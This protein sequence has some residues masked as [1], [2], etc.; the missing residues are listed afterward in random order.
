M[1]GHAIECRISTE[2]PWNN[3]LPSTG[4]ITNMREPTNEYVDVRIDS[5]VREGDLV[6]PYY[7]PMI[8]KV[9]AHGDNREHA[10]QKMSRAL[11]EYQIIG[12]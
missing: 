10:I 8:A 9:I 2:D 7:D 3:F 5:G 11:G 1:F 4:K 6:T 12:V